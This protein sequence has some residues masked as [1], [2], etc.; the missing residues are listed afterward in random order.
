MLEDGNSG[1][2]HYWERNL[3]LPPGGGNITEF[4][5]IVKSIT[6]I[7]YFGGGTLR[8]YKYPLLVK[9]LPLI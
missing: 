7:K 4:V 5:D 6:I 2:P 9:F 1:K 3:T 8:L